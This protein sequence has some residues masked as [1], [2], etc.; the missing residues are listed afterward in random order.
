MPRF[1]QVAFDVTE[2]TPAQYACIE[3]WLNTI[4]LRKVPHVANTFTGECKVNSDEAAIALVRECFAQATFKCECEGRLHVT[5][6][7]SAI[8]EDHVFDIKTMMAILDS[9]RK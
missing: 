8:E 1:V 2:G 6:S 7:P 5:V 9:L 4:Y 3:G